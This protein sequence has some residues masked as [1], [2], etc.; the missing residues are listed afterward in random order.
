[1]IDAVAKSMTMPDLADVEAIIREVARVEIVP[2]F[3][4]LRAGEIREKNEPGDPDMGD[5]SEDPEPD[6]GEPGPMDPG[7][8]P[9]EPLPTAD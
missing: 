4:A 3:R 2:R 1:M 6:Q 7:P 5:P 8:N 9:D